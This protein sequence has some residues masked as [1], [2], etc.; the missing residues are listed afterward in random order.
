MPITELRVAGY[1]SV[2]DLTLTLKRVN[3]VV[4]PNGCGKSNVYK[5]LG[6]LWAA[7]Q[8]RLAHT[9]AEEGGMPSILWAGPRKQG[10]VRVS[11]GVTLD[12]LEYDIELGLATPSL[13]AF[14]LD[15][16]IKSERLVLVERGRRT[17]LVDRGTSGCTLRDAEGERQTYTMELDHS[18]SVMVQIVDAHRYP[19]LARLRHA[20]SSWRFYHQF[21]S[22]PQSPLRTPQVGVRTWAL[23]PDGSDLAAA[24]QTVLESGDGRGLAEAVAAA[25]G[26]SALTTTAGD[27]RFAV[28]L[29]V[30][31]LARALGAHELSDGQMRYLCLLAALMSP[32][33]APLMALNEPETNLHPSLTAHLADLVARAADLS[34][35]WIT[36][37][38][39]ELA[40]RI[41]ERMGVAPIRLLMEEG[42]TRKEGM[43]KG[44]FFAAEE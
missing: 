33:P 43:P 20:I 40:E 13:T 10:P 35:V 9:L 1:R 11:V 38:S 18:A 16:Q 42:E 6:L 44:R 27:G 31:E 25:F 15:P 5:A 21:R 29:T 17:V 3:V 7:A 34:Q 26:G 32:R 37:H 12:D 19:H 30:P 41:Q 14:S 4:G 28:G 8:G 24:L 36:T 2:V 23:A 39:F 22:D